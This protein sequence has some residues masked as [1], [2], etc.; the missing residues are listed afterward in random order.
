M[1]RIAM[2]ASVIASAFVL[3]GCASQS[4]NDN[5]PSKQVAAPVH[6]HDYKGEG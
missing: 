2:I 3:F 6:H 5:V 4:P 1:K